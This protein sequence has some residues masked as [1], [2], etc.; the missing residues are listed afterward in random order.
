MGQSNR[1]TMM[2]LGL[3]LMLA[4]TLAACPAPAPGTPA[5]GETPG[6]DA[7]GETIPGGYQQQDPA[8]AGM[9][10]AATKAVELL[11]ERQNE[12]SLELITLTAAATQVV[13]GLNYDLTM[14]VR[15]PQGDK[16]VRVV[17]YRDLEQAYSLTSVEGL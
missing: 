13:A 4:G 6:S 7:S 2:R 14:T 5:G 8:D 10:A 17:M 15:T 11:G 1:E 16:Q 9:Q 3:G 12:P